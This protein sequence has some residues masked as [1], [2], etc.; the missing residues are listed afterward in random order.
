V[1]AARGL[2]IRAL[3]VEVE[4]DA[5]LVLKARLALVSAR[6]LLPFPHGLRAR[7]D[8]SLRR[9]KVGLEG[10]RGLLQPGGVDLCLQGVVAQGPLPL[11]RYLGRPR[12]QYAHAGSRGATA[13]A[14]KEAAA[15]VLERDVLQ[16][17]AVAAE[18]NGPLRA[19][20]KREKGKSVAS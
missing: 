5:L 9:G 15:G 13:D 11:P 20:S 8:K 2:E 17:H 7:I 4:C 1:A 16:R 10:P 6:L 19:D 12:R 18:R 3:P 14:Q